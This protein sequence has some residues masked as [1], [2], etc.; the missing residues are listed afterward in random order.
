[1]A[2]TPQPIQ[3]SV[4]TS[5]TTLYTAFVG[6]SATRAMLPSLT[7]TNTTS[8]SIT[9][10]VWID[11]GGVLFYILKTFPIAGLQTLDWTG[12]QT[13]DTSTDKFRAQASATG[14][15]ATGTVIENA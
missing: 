5:A 7:L 8:A 9:I 13:L 11:N 4:L 3:V 12:M 10:D 1:M 6:G 15:D 2:S 14:I